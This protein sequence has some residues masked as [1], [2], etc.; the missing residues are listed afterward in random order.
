MLTF[1]TKGPAQLWQNLGLPGDKP[2]PGWKPLP[3][4][5]PFAAA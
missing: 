4:R 1:Y 2:F 5:F 3:P